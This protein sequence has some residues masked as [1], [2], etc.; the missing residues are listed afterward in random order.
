MCCVTKRALLQVRV[1]APGLSEFSCKAET[2]GGEGEREERMGQ[3]GDREAEGW[4]GRRRR[5]ESCEREETKVNLVRAI[6][7]LIRRMEFQ[8]PRTGD[9]GPDYCL[10]PTRIISSA[11]KKSIGV[12]PTPTRNLLPYF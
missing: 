6:I 10:A 8:G 9:S 2:T 5:T 1:I 11:K 12:F 4:R 3:G 7:R